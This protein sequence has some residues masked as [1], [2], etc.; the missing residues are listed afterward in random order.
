MS[1]M[2][3]EDQKNKS[4]ISKIS[5]SN[6]QDNVSALLVPPNP[7][8]VADID[9]STSATQS[10]TTISTLAQDYPEKTLKMK[11]IFKK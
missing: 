5:E 8:S 1:T 9:S 10:T 3:A 2:H 4:L 7:T 11:I 6:V